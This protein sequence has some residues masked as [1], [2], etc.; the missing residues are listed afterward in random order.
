MRPV[1]VLLVDDHRL[2]RAGIRLVLGSMQDI[3]VVGEADEGTEALSLIEQKEPDVVLLDLAMAG[4][5]GMETLP[6]IRKRYPKVRVLILSCSGGEEYVIRALRLGASGYL[7][8]DAVTAEL[9][10]ALHTVVGG[11]IFLS[12][13]VSTTVVRKIL[14]SPGAEK[15]DEPLT[16]RQRQILQLIAQGKTTKEIAAMLN[17]KIKTVEAHRLQIMDRL[18][19][20]HLSGLILYAIR[21]G[22][23]SV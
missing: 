15:E 12:P 5:T 19:I 20:H 8:K 1:R 10:M 21:T 2:V 4:M 6:I 18:G 14:Q 16:E 23:I 13:S 11:Q 7:V 3:V 22:L 9:E 17:V